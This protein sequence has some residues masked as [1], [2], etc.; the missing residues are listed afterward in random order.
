MSR[1]VP[2][3][4][5]TEPEIACVRRGDVPEGRT[6]LQA[7]SYAHKHNIPW[8]E[9]RRD[10]GEWWW[11]PDEDELLHKGG[12]PEGRTWEAI[13][14]HKDRIGIPRDASPTYEDFKEYYAIHK[15]IDG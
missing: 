8:K 2:K 13:R 4:R 10:R 6:Y 12:I 3:K 9:L 7:A 5:W 15:R 1:N 11:R 14:Q